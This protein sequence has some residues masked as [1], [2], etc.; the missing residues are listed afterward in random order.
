MAHGSG[1]CRA[2]EEVCDN[3]VLR[4]SDGTSYAET[5]LDVCQGLQRSAM[6]GAQLGLF[7]RPWRLEQRVA[8]LLDVNRVLLTRIRPIR[9]LVLFAVLLAALTV[10]A[11]VRFLIAN[12]T[13]PNS[14]AGENPTTE[15]V[16]ALSPNN[17]PA[18]VPDDEKL[19]SELGLQPM[20]SLEDGRD[21]CRR[22]EA[23]Q[24]HCRTRPN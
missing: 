8:G 4:D 9:A 20:Q 13:A 1:D 14:P 17:D 16:R 21:Q 24:A 18:G 10:S 5:L 7:E 22:V 6:N 19:V 15:T 23:G 12:S 2:R 11:G 3:Y